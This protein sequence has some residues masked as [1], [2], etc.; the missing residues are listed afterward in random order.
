M[1]RMEH[2]VALFS[3]AENTRFSEVALLIDYVVIYRMD[4]YGAFFSRNIWTRL[5]P[6]AR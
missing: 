4:H 2:Y 6:I 1:K 5:V 3:E